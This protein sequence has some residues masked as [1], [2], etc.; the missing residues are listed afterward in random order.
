MDLVLNAT[1]SATTYLLETRTSDGGWPYYPGDSASTEPSAL[2]GLALHAYG[3]ADLL[4]ATADWI[5]ARQRDDGWMTAS[6]TH[7]DPSWATPLGALLLSVTGDP[8]S[9]GRAAH[10]LLSANVFS[11]EPALA[12]GIYN[13]D[14]R[15]RGWPWTPDGFSFTEPTA[16]AVTFLKR[17]GYGGEPRVPEATRMLR[18]R[19]L[20]GG[21]WNYGEPE[22][23]GGVLFPAVVPTAQAL[24]ALADDQNGTTEAGLDWLLA[25]RGQISTLF[26]LGWACIAL[27]ALDRLDDDWRSDL[28]AAWEDAP[29]ARRGPME[30]A[31][32][33]LAL[34]PRASNPLL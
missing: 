8:G 27:A 18:G 24:L 14:T 6:T 3:L 16:L 17:F 21:G 12:R 1:T 13:Y 4:P 31:L 30:A 7:A 33:L 28:A 15:S 32:L 22:V 26:S 11:F 19:A 20:P 9:A 29:P 25:Q 34:A 10:A 23:L 2:A 5:R